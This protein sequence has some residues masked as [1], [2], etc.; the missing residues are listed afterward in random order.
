MFRN[1][2]RAGVLVTSSLC[3]VG[4][5]QD[6]FATDNNLPGVID[7]E[8]PSFTIPKSH[9]IDAEQKSPLAEAPVVEKTENTATTSITINQ[10]DFSGSSVFSEEELLA[11]ASEFMNTPISSAELAQLKYKITKLYYDNGYVLVKVVTPPQEIASGH[12]TV[13]IYEATIDDINIIDNGVVS[14]IVAQSIAKTLRL[15][16]IFNEKS[17]ESMISD[18]NDLH[19]ISATATLKPGNEFKST[20]VDVAFTPVDEDENYVH[21]DNYGHE[22]TGKNVLTAHVEKSNALAIGEKIYATARASDDSL[23][24]IAVGTSLPTT[25]KNVTA[26]VNYLYSENDIDGTLQSGTSHIFNLS[27]NSK[28]INTGKEIA[29][30]GV[31]F[32]SRNHESEINGLSSART[33]DDIRQVY[34]AASYVYRGD[35]SVWYAGAKISKGLDILNASEK[36]APDASRTANGGGDPE[37]IK[38]EPVIV[39]NLKPN[40]DGIVKFVAS[41]QLSSDTL[42]ASDL[43]VLG[44]YGNVRGFEPA[45][46]SGESGYQFSLEY[47][48]DLPASEDFDLSVGPFIDGGAVYNRVSGNSVDSHLYS[49]G[50]GVEVSTNLIP[51]EETLLRLDWAHPLGSYSATN[52]DDNRFY[53]RLTQKF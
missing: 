35:S 43:F 5:A 14:S 49:A 39:A 53:F 31:G 30:V 33:E 51:S 36:G 29:S 10:I 50:I 23:R 8:L 27:L 4:G 22:L 40:T 41:G 38:L 2:L 52:V 37:A 18:L 20:T 16:T 9:R 19:G 46:E 42:L 7:R 47:Q 6:S 15:N 12:L 28:L 13:N 25:I 44:G 48:H 32:E 26:D 34:G 3:I 24:S 17:V 45:Q 1:F 11:E 21:V